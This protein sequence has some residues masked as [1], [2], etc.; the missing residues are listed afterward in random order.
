MEERLWDPLSHLPMC[1]S[2]PRVVGWSGVRERAVGW[3]NT[4]PSHHQ[5]GR[6]HRHY[7][8][9]RPSMPLSFAR[10][11]F[12]FGH[13]VGGWIQQLSGWLARRDLLIA[14]PQAFS[15]FSFFLFLCYWGSL[16]WEKFTT[17]VSGGGGG[18]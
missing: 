6:H 9:H 4:G 10:V 18:T 1:R 15:F 13:Y 2:R 3:L 8:C 7:H 17:E 14:L 16:S 11:S 5:H 12:Y